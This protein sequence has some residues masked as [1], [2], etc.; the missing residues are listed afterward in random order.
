MC[1]LLIPSPISSGNRGNNHRAL[2]VDRQKAYK[3]S[4][5]GAH[6]YK[7]AGPVLSDDCYLLE[8][9]KDWREYLDEKENSVMTSTLFQNTKT[10]RPCGE[11]A[12]I[13]TIENIIGRRLTA[14]PVGRPRKTK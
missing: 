6:V 13:S 1:T 2:I 4:S 8:S 12:F 9:V 3:W 7:D 10:G 5:A 11:D 14:L